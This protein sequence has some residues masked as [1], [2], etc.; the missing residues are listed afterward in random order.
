MYLL[1]M[2]WPILAMGTAYAVLYDMRRLLLINRAV[3]TRSG[4]LVGCL[5]LGPFAGV[6]YLLVRPSVRRRLIEQVWVMA[7]DASHP[8]D[9]RLKR[10]N[11]MRET[12]LISQ[13]VLQDCLRKLE[14][15]VTK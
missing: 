13:P 3:L 7:G 15:E 2:T 14:Q 9:A 11:T 5:C 12:G 10:L 6:A 1:V 4:W 8:M